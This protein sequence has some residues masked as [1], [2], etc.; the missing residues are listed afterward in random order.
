MTEQR[1]QW[2]EIQTVHITYRWK[3]KWGG[4]KWKQ[5]VIIRRYVHDSFMGN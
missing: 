1:E 5:P 3:K 4:G 2:C